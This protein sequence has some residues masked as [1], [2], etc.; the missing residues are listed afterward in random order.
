MADI[1]HQVGI[2]APPEKIFE[3]LSTD[4]GLSQWW[5]NVVSGAGEVG[6]V[7][8]FRFGEGGPDFSVAELVP[9]R[10]VRWKHHGNMPEQWMGTEVLFEI[11]E[12]GDQSLVRF[13]HANWKETTDF[14]A[15]CSTKWA[16]FLLSLKDAL[17]LGKGRPYPDD[18]HINHT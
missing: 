12:D 14:L 4:S 9:N 3:L 2:K 13:T 6:S 11:S 18:I 5:T 17:E 16:V 8:A 10:L 15:H 1:N 7:I